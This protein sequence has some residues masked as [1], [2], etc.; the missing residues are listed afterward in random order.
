MSKVEISPTRYE[1]PDGPTA[2]PKR[3][4]LYILTM[5]CSDTLQVQVL[6]LFHEYEIPVVDETYHTILV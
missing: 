6:H 5:W 4:V 1:I 3:M 2:T